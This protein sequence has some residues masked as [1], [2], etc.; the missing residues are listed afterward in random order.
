MVE[1]TELHL[2]DQQFMPKIEAGQGMGPAH[3]FRLAG[4]SLF[5][6]DMDGEKAVE[7]AVLS[8][9][10]FVVQKS[11]VQVPYPHVLAF[12]FMK[13]VGGYHDVTITAIL[14]GFKHVD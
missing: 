2:A 8:Q 10:A 5:T 7:F 6:V 11:R 14:Q 13:I 3:G 12:P 9:K 4:I 1:A